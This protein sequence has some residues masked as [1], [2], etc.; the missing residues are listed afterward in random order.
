MH[1]ASNTS[2]LSLVHPIQV[3]NWKS[4]LIEEGSGIFD[5][6]T[7]REKKDQAVQEAELFEQIGR[8][9]MKLKWLK[10]KLSISIESK[11]KM[12]EEN[13][14]DLS[15]RRQCELLGLNRSTYYQRPDQ[16]SD[17]NLQSM[18][19]IDEEDM[20]A[21]FYG[22]RKMTERIQRQTGADVNRKRIARLMRKMGLQAIYPKKN[23][24]IPDCQHRKYPYLLRNLKIDRVDQ[25]WA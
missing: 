22:Y 2:S 7:D 5:R 1:S 10:K 14:P 8:L 19:M 17:L 12:I 4:K 16:E 20:K 18:R 25:V 6:R 21:P 15:V 13:H 23:A 24:S 9:K 11:R 3:R